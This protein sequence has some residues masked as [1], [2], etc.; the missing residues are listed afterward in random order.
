MFLPSSS[1]YLI[2][3][4]C[5]HTGHIYT[6][7]LIINFIYLLRLICGVW[8]INYGR[9]WKTNV[10]VWQP[11]KTFIISFA[12]TTASVLELLVADVL[13]PLNSH[14]PLHRPPSL[15]KIKCEWKLNTGMMS[16]SHVYCCILRILKFL[17]SLW[18]ILISHF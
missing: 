15:F 13:W 7:L 5:F 17:F 6:F 11:G 2:H 4:L 1:C 3:V 16:V 14:S 10:I 9:W 8:D 18:K 12:V